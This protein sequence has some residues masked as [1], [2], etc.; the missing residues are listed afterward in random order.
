MRVLLHIVSAFLLIVLTGGVW[1]V[2]PF[3][4]VAPDLGL[5]V[6]VYLGAS[7]RG[8]AWEHTMAAMTIGYLADVVVGAP[9]GL[10]A[11]VLGCACL[12]T[13]LGTARFLVRGSLFTGV[14]V[15]AAGI[16]SGSLTLL[17]RAAFGATGAP[18][19]L[20]VMSVVGS[21][22]LTAVLAPGVF[23]ICRAIDGRFA[24][25][26]REREALREGFLV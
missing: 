16:V 4:V 6:A 22:F 20:E 17:L 11:L 15:F 12:L 1:R 14:F 13:R 25:T 21:A 5:V 18:L 10:G 24:R 2:L 26:E 23:R 19:S 9:R 7:L 3:D 8:Q